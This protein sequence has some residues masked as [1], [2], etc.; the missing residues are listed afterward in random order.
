MSRANREDKEIRSQL[1][2]RRH[3]DQ[4][5]VWTI[6]HGSGIFRWI[7]ITTEEYEWYKTH[8]LSKFKLSIPEEIIQ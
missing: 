6:I 7:Y 1:K 3:K 2:L 4:H 8:F 5:Q